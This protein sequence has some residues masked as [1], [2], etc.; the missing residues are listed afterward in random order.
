MLARG[1]PHA[2][3]PDAF[4]TALSPNMAAFHSVTSDMSRCAFRQR[5]DLRDGLIVV[6]NFAVLI[7]LDET[8]VERRDPGRLVRPHQRASNA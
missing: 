5:R 3:R 4:V 7:E 6:R 8:L 2:R 1:N